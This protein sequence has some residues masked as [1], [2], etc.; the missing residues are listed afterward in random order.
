MYSFFFTITS[1]KLSNSYGILFTGK[2]A[3]KSSPHIK[4]KFSIS[5]LLGVLSDGFYAGIKTIDSYNPTGIL[6]KFE[7]LGKSFSLI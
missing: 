1:F 2:E 3:K 6:F 5:L 4:L 7:S